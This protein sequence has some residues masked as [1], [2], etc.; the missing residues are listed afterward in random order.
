MNS[1]GMEATLS[2]FRS[3]MG[4]NV[5]AVLPGKNPALPVLVV[6]AHYDSR[7]RSSSSPTERAPGA[8]DDG[9]GS[10]LLLELATVISDSNVQ[11]EH[12][13]HFHFYC[14]EEQGLVGSRAEARKYKAAGIE[15]VAMLQA[16]MVA[17]RKPGEAMQVGLPNRGTTPELAQFLRDLVPNYVD[18]VVGAPNVCC[19]DQQSW[20]SEG[21][22]AA[23]FFER[24]GPLTDPQYHRSGDL[25]QRQGYDIEQA[26]EISKAF[27][28]SMATL[29]KLA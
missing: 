1:L 26:V 14:G 18:L 10:S 4:P 9:S 8:N 24:A 19:S 6:G 12:T 20:L 11:F 29:A 3:D 13:V 15:L 27:L 23:F 16:D 2:E 28:A 5:V 17:Y 21:Y 7:G 22:R 25:V